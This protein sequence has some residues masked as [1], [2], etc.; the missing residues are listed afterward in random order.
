MSVSLRPACDLGVAI[1]PKARTVSSSDRRRQNRTHG[2]VFRACGGLVARRAAKNVVSEQADINF[3]GGEE[4]RYFGNLEA[5][6][7]NPPGRRRP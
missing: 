1:N 5:G 6:S 2:T 7:E 3:A 4:H